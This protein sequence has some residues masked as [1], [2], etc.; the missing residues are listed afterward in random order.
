MNFNPLFIQTVGADESAG[1]IKQLKLSKNSYLFSDIVKLN[2][3]K[4]H[5]SEGDVLSAANMEELSSTIATDM[6]IEEMMDSMLGMPSLEMFTVVEPKVLNGLVE[7]VFQAKNSVESSEELFALNYDVNIDKA[8]KSEIYGSEEK[9]VEFL[10]QLIPGMALIDT[11]NPDNIEISDGEENAKGLPLLPLPDKSKVIE[12]VL[13]RLKAGQNVQITAKVGDEKIKLDIQKVTDQFGVK[14]SVP[15]TSS[16]AE[17]LA[18][19]EQPTDE[20]ASLTGTGEKTVNENAILK[21]VT[22]ANTE[23]KVSEVNKKTAK[24]EIKPSVADGI[25]T[26][27]TA[28]GKENKASDEKLTVVS[29]LQNE[30]EKSSSTSE[31]ESPKK[32]GQNEILNKASVAVKEKEINEPVM[33]KKEKAEIKVQEKAGN[34][35]NE[36]KEEIKKSD[37][38]I[39]SE[40][41]GKTINEKT[42][43]DVSMVAESKE[44]ESNVK[45]TKTISSEKK[46]T[47]TSTDVKNTSSAKD[48]AGLDGA[49]MAIQD[50]SIDPLRRLAKTDAKKDKYKIKITQENKEESGHKEIKKMNVEVD[51]LLNY[52]KQTRQ[53][54]EKVNPQQQVQEQPA[55]EQTKEASEVKV[56]ENTNATEAAVKHEVKV[57]K[58]SSE[59]KPLNTQH[60]NVTTKTVHNAEK[61]LHAAES[62]KEVARTVKSSQLMQE[63]KSFLETSNNNK[64][65]VMK[66]LPENLGKVKVTLDL[67]DSQMHA[68]V[69]VENEAVKQV[70]LSNI[71]GLKQSLAQSGVQ[72]GGFNVSLTNQD[73]RAKRE[74]S[75]K[76]KEEGGSDKIDFKEVSEEVREKKLG[77]NT[78]E[79]HSI[80]AKMVDGVSSSS[81]YNSYISETTGD[82]EMG[83]EDFLLLMIEQLKNQDP[84][85][86]LDGSEY[87]AQLAQFTSLEQLTNLNEAMQQSIDANYILTQSINNTMTATLIG[88]EAKI[89]GN[90]I[91]YSGQDN[92]NLGYDLP[93]DASSVTVKVYNEAGALIK[94]F[95]S[96]PTTAGD[97]KLSWDFTDNNGSKLST[98]SYSFEVEA[99]SASGEEMTLVT[100]K[101]G[102]IEGIKFTEDGA[103][104]TVNGASYAPSDI[105]E[106]INP[107]SSGE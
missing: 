74:F 94:T 76:K 105:L 73:Q 34:T 61:V 68:N 9:L 99:K 47:E 13:N 54:E 7:R 2:Y 57:E 3:E 15:A 24:Q 85:D 81:T 72:V 70:M 16:I 1:N 5:V 91:E 55:A 65:L 106:L 60:N 41:S 20:T 10:E 6:S 58:P 59:V 56:A 84:L 21:N 49:K 14:V 103:Y 33:P 46:V 22:S 51:N 52:K 100:Y 28:K 19:V 26:E 78:Y 62:V 12:D 96:A 64:Q 27:E 67:V 86:P 102:T 31:V 43:S 48:I 11:S 36:A 89:D 25:K 98:G 66:L 97:H 80:E 50:K 104:M 79:I 4:T 30:T 44:T 83:K 17:K 37:Q 69:E 35:K 88:K 38:K 18:N 101:Y 92:V 39:T 63:M 40:V 107:T 77:Y 45:A 32:A 90:A 23:V 42:K 95:E 53:F 75:Q 71:E 87:A 8:L 29:N 82:S 93:A